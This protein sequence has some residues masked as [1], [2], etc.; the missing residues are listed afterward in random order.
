VPKITE[1]LNAEKQRS[2]AE[3]LKLTEQ[4][5]DMKRR[6]EKKTAGDLGDEA[7]LDL[8]D[9]LKRE[10]AGDQIARVPKGRTGPD[11]IHR[12]VHNG[13]VCGTI[14]YDCK[15]HRRWLNHFTTKLRKDAE[16]AD[17]AVLVTTVFPAASQQRLLATKD[18]VLIVAPHM[19]V[20]VAHLLRRQTI[21][22][23]GLRLT[24]E[25]RAEKAQQLYAFVTSDRANHLWSK[26]A[27]ATNELLA[28][29]HS[30]KI[31]HEKIWGRRADLIRDLKEA[32]RSFG[33]TVDRVIGGTGSEASL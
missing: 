27:G 16:A 23:H 30:E 10:F 19:A 20:A 22:I 4:L 33:E 31:T 24:N 17:H 21:Q 13:T 3:K 2:Y 6:L 28:L 32:H 5:E 1:A 9:A 11:I 8:F 26:I 18:G 7:E 12:I 29:D 15:N 14:V 25:G